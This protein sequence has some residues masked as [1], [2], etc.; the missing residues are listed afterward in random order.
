MK[1]ILF[2]VSLL[3]W[4]L[5]TAQNN[6]IEIPIK[7]QNGYG[8]FELG[9]A[10]IST[11]SEDK[12]DPLYKTYVESK[13]IPKGWTNVKKGS[14]EING[15]QFIYQN[16]LLG[17]ISK[18]YYESS[19]S[20]LNW[21]PENL[22]LSKKELKCTIAFAYTKDITGKIKMV[23]DANNNHDFSDEKIFTPIAIKSFND[24]SITNDTVL[25]EQSIIVK[26]ESE[27]NNVIIEK[28]VPLSI[29]HIISDD[30]LLYNFPQYLTTS[31]EGEKIAIC[32]NRF[33]DISSRD[34]LI[35][36]MDDNT[37]K[38][39]YENYISINEFV[40]LKNK[41]YK[42]KGLNLNKNVLMLEQVDLPYNQLYST[43]IGFKPF[44]FEGHDFKT[45]SEIS[46]DK[47][48]GKYLLIDFW[49]TWCKPC[50]EELANLKKIYDTV[51]KSK[52]EILGI[53]GDSQAE[54]LEDRII[55]S[56]INWAQIQSDNKNKI[57]KT[58]GIIGYPTTF[59]INPDGVIVA[60]N[61]RG[62]DLENRINELIKNE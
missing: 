27:V 10:S 49:A 58:Y 59:L 39:D 60:K 32:S 30:I 53:V 28:T 54:A 62:K 51:D 5:S 7:A 8:P 1:I 21:S 40:K 9:F 20:K 35:A 17:K 36:I 6:I 14:I 41:I 43:Q 13:G 23:I 56:S 38:V 55:K 26:F 47:Y 34:P 22:F 12:N 46:L 4:N 2:L 29:I 18:N 19:T 31:F 50:I 33:T 42:N 52:F 48:K 45:K 57:S 25:F 3:C 37:K 16:Y 61:L 44:P 11:Y 15:V 24:L